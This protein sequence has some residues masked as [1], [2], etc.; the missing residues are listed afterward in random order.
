MTLLSLS[1][2]LSLL[3]GASFSWA[4]LLVEK[5]SQTEESSALESRELRESI[6][7]ARLKECI[8]MAWSIEPLGCEAC[9]ALAGIFTTV[10]NGD[11]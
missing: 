2:L 4:L 1:L 6:G 3:L 9:P 10:K 8:A 7:E 11:G 5:P